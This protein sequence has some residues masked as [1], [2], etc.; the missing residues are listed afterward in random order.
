MQDRKNTSPGGGGLK[1][2]QNVSKNKYIYK[3]ELE[4]LKVKDIIQHT[5]ARYPFEY[6]S[7]LIFTSDAFI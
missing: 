7:F 3:I 4:S 5:V 2:K 1:D 6:S